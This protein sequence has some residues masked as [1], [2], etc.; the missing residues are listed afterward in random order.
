MPDGTLAC[1]NPR[2]TA[3]ASEHAEAQNAV[4]R[5]ARKDSDVRK[6][7]DSEVLAAAHSQAVA[8]YDLCVRAAV[9]SKVPSSTYLRRPA[10]T[11]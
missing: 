10:L 4:D 8:L 9:T 2:S 5:A 3:C 11:D 6:I 7:T 1:L